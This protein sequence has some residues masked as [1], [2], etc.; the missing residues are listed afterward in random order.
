MCDPSQ[1]RW[2]LVACVC[3]VDGL[4]SMRGSG[5]DA[6]PSVRWSTIMYPVP[7][8]GAMWG[9]QMQQ[10]N[11]R[12]GAACGR[13]QVGSQSC[14]RVWGHCH[15]HSVHVLT[16]LPIGVC[17]HFSP[18]ACRAGAALPSCLWAQQTAWRCT[19]TEEADLVPDLSQICL[20][21]MC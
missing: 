7:V 20:R 13:L 15:A 2:G 11:R 8:C 4:T 21:L 5:S 12:C 16:L 17:S 1:W 3:M 9:A 6:V 10:A 18:C 19:S 14:G